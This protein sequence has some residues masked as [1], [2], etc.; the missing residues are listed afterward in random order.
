M[1]L[2]RFILLACFPIKIQQHPS[3]PILKKPLNRQNQENPSPQ[4]TK[5]GHK[6]P[7]NY[8]IKSLLLGLIACIYNYKEYV[9]PKVMLLI[10][11]FY[12]Y[13]SLDMGLAMFAA[14][15]RAFL[16]LE[17]EPQFDDPYLSTSL[18]D[19]WGRRWN[20]MVSSILRPTVYDPVRS[21]SSRLIGRKWA[22]ATG[23]L[24]TFMVSGLMHELI[25]FYFK[26]EKPTWEITCFFLLHGVCLVV[27]TSLRKAFKGKFW[28][29]PVVSR[30][31]AVAFLVITSTWLFFPPLLSTD[32]DIRLRKESIAL[33][34]FVKDVRNRL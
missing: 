11:C 13:L 19:F 5:K 16:R 29:P 9:H 28:L 12:I 10:Y 34:E 25:L 14:L 7:L 20:L 4:I 3:P 6:S 24:A 30:P 2:P 18:Q 23:I 21:F 22:I 15:A 27:E 8:A 26:P 31:L 33:I 32:I 1:S 17:L